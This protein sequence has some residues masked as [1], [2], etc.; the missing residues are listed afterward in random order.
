VVAAL[1]AWFMTAGPAPA[2]PASRPAGDP[3]EG[4]WPMWG[5]RPSRNM[6]AA[7][8]RLP[9]AWD[10]TERTNVRWI[11]NLGTQTFGNPVVSGGKVFIGTNNG[12]PRNPRIKG[13]KGVLMCF[14][15]QDGRFLWQAVHDKLPAGDAQDWADI[16]VCSTPC[17]TGDRVY[18]VSNR[19][20]LVCADTEGFADGENDGPFRDEQHAGPADA[21]VVWSLDMLAVLGVIPLNA[22]AS[23]PLVVGERVFVVTGNGVDDAEG[24]VTTPQAPSFIAVDRN[25]GKVLWGSN[26]PGDRILAGQWSS[27]AYGVVKGEPQVCFPGGDG[28]VYAFAPADGRML[29]KFNCKA[30]ERPPEK[31]EPET[32]NHIVAAPVYYEDRVFIAVGQDPESGDGPGALWAIDATGRGDVT[33]TGE[34]WRLAGKDFGRSISTVAVRDGLLYA[35]ELGGYLNCIEAATGKRFWRHDLNAHVWGSP[36]LA[37]DKVCVTNE[38]GAVSIFAHG[39]EARLLATV[40]MPETLYCTPVLAGGVLYLADRSRLYAIAEP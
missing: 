6:V 5:G 25:T 37:G 26:A 30:A 4:D 21:D 2:E 35:V 9:T 15:A 19:G 40:A 13:D 8:T 36:L 1:A 29:W 28:W 31:G 17:V 32:R 38:D 11:A 34:R 24:K 20:E 3:P 33:A 23:S 7:E 16:G 27:P 10:V 39:R 14:S 22:S 18:Y 12:R